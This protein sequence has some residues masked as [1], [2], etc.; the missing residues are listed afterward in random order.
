MLKM[1][2]TSVTQISTNTADTMN[3]PYAGSITTDDNYIY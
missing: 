3:Q 2:I 1:P